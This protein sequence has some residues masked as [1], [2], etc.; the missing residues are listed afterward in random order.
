MYRALESV[1]FL[2]CGPAL[3]PILPRSQCW[4]IDQANSKFVLQIRQPIY[5]RIELPVSNVEESR[6]AQE[7]R[8]I[9]DGVLRL[10]RTRCPFQWDSTGS[11][12]ARRKLLSWGKSWSPALQDSTEEK[13]GNYE[14]FGSSAIDA[15]AFADDGSWKRRCVFRD[16]HRCDSGIEVAVDERLGQNVDEARLSNNSC[17]TVLAVA[18]LPEAGCRLEERPGRVQFCHLLSPDDEFSSNNLG[19]P[20]STPWSFFLEAIAV[21]RRILQL[22]VTL[23]P[24]TLTS[25][26]VSVHERQRPAGALLGGFILPFWDPHSTAAVRLLPMFL[27]RLF[28]TLTSFQITPSSADSHSGATAV[29]A[30]AR[31]SGVKQYLDSLIPDAD[32]GEPTRTWVRRTTVRNLGAEGDFVT[33][34]LANP[35]LPMKAT[36]SRPPASDLR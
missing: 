13:G 9:L 16:S 18:I 25:A 20:A 12:A 36:N 4:C 32:T 15:A 2:S 7:F 24:V 29:G 33:T 5:W 23:S 35:S 10:Q 14:E 3:H 30:Y 28:E 34:G 26:T 1:A 11:I 6:R 8:N 17:G 19:T 31:I 22:V 27:T 21:P